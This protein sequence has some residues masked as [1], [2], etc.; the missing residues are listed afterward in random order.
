MLLALTIRD[1]I[2]IDRLELAF[3]PGF[4]ALTGETGA[5]KSILLDAL[6]LAL[7]ARAERGLVRPGAERGE[8]VAVFDPPPD[9][10]VRARLAEQGFEAEGEIVLRRQLTPEG[11]SRAWIQQLPVTGGFLREVGEGLV[12]VH[13]QHA[14]RGLLDPASHRRLLDAFAG[15]EPLVAELRAA[16]RD[17]QARREALEALRAELEQAASEREELRL[18]VEELEALA[19]QPG[20]EAE[21]ARRRRQLAGR[22]R[23]L[24]LLREAA[25]LLGTAGERL[26]A[27]ERRL[28]RG[29]ELAG[30]EL[31][32]AL[33]A[34]ERA[35][36]ETDEAEAQLEALAREL[37][38]QPGALERIEERLFALRDA[39][40]K[41][42][43]EVEALPALLEE[44]RK[45]LARLAGGSDELTA[46]EREVA[47][48]RARLEALA[49]E[50]S[51]RRREAALRL[52][53]AVAAELAPLRLER[54]RFRVELEPLEGARL[55]P[56]GAERVRFLVR[57]NPGAPW[58]PLARI[59]SG[60][61]LARFMLA[62]EVVLARADPIPTMVF[63][64]V[65]QGIGGAVADAVGERL[66]RLGRER[67]VL[68]VTHA[69]QV[70]ARAHHHLRVVKEEDGTGVRVRVE[71]LAGEAR[72]DEIARMLAGAHITDAAR[73]AATSLL[74]AASGAQP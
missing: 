74:R 41:F 33:A 56:E 30:E 1:I 70:A 49:R 16:W 59:A 61:E 17:W 40:R 52:S 26:A 8:V 64:E 35:R 32:A 36:I 57:T 55:G 58:G 67:Q 73:A 29:R 47:A 31:D 7:G 18:R 11:R 44:S 2:L 6:G 50:L 39:A 3:E 24:G 43:V 10:P 53:E 34:L 4:T 66:A 22:E 54:A 45:R 68:A 38:V 69:P 19:P 60:G 65:D 25:E 72:R 13:G 42:R 27:A 51:R 15:T 28:E 48:A 9:H 12:E 37:D 23:L 5:G 46:C 14:V 71:V 62:L 21:L 63:D 20:E